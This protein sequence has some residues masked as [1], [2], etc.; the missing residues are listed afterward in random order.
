[1]I[2]VKHLSKT[3]TDPDGSKIT[4]LKDVNCEIKQGE[5]ISIIGPSG[6]GKSTFLRALNML[7]PPTGGEIWVDGEN[8]MAKG[9]RLDKLRQKMGMVFQNFNLFDHM[10]VV[11][12]I[13]YA[14]MR[15]RGVPEEEARK[16]AMELLSKVG[17][18]QKA[19]VY[20]SSLSGGQK[21]RVAIARSLAMHP[22]VILFDEPT[23]ALD[24]TMVGE[25]LSVMRQLAKDGLTMLIV[26]HEMRFAR[27]VSTRIFFMNEGIIYEDGTPQQIFEH[28]VHSATKAFVNR[29]QK[30][31]YEI[32][33]DNFDFLGIGSDFNNFCVKYNLGAKIDVISEVMEEM[34]FTQLK[35]VRPLTLRLTYAALSDETA[36]DFMV[37]GAT[38]SPLP[39]GSAMDGIRAKVQQVIEEPTTRGFRVKILI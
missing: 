13:T 21:Q 14:P 11:E 4:V 5:V 29:I 35:D 31:V 28:P 16:E 9:Y 27:D 8:I 25:V 6:T 20:P 15:L 1:M 24:P 19:D 12:N 26:T 7:E 10:T 2:S 18:A 39:Q 17:L 3:F 37:E 32:D 38:T 30:L 22:E 23:S 34:L 33:S 36:L